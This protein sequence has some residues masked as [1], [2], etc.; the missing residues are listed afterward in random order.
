MNLAL[1]PSVRWTLIVVVLVIALF[2]LFNVG[3]AKT[4]SRT[5]DVLSFTPPAGWETT[6]KPGPGP[7]TMSNVNKVKGIF[8]EITVYNS[9]QSGKN[10]TSDFFS[11]WTAII[12]SPLPN[13][14][15]VSDEGTRVAGVALAV[16]VSGQNNHVRLIT[17]RAGAKIASIVIL[18]PNSKAY[19]VYRPEIDSFLAS[20]TVNSVASGTP[21]IDSPERAPETTL[22]ASDKPVWVAEWKKSVR[23]SDLS[24]EWRNTERDGST[25]WTAI[26]VIRGDGSF[27]SSFEQRGSVTASE[28]NKGTW[29]LSPRPLLKYVKGHSRPF[30]ILHFTRLPDGSSTMSILDSHYPI[31]ETNRAAYESKYTR[32][33]P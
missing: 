9:L 11:E 7:M 23:M 26:L 19:E 30:N 32:A 20:V 28:E 25:Y 17:Y 27:T 3:A 8:C 24:G 22:P 21:R 1:S 18:T 2:G 4:H 15:D 6:Q 33:A 31:N 13:A 10:L 29:T 5:V 12:G 16:P 14:G